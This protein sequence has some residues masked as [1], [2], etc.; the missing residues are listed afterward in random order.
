M[1][2]F[3]SKL[4][5]FFLTHCLDSSNNDTQ[6]HG[7]LLCLEIAYDMMGELPYYV[8]AGRSA[9][10]AALSLSLSLSSGPPVLT[11]SSCDDALLIYAVL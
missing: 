4:L 3:V 7:R 1:T 2:T 8:C 11:L 9:L 5:Y 6:R 10:T